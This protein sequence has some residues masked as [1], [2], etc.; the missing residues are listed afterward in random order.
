MSVPEGI[1]REIEYFRLL[2]SRCW[3]TFENQGE[4][5]FSGKAGE[6]RTHHG[7][8]RCGGE[9]SILVDWFS[10]PLF[11]VFIKFGHNIIMS[12]ERCRK[13]YVK[14]RLSVVNVDFSQRI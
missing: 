14:R 1:M 7:A 9:G 4:R 6:C 8:G 13:D 3:G 12:Y 10:L 5:D 11:Y 2:T